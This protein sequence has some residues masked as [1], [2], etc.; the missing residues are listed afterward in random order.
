MAKRQVKFKRPTKVTKLD[1]VQQMAL[2]RE[3]LLDV[4]EEMSERVTVPNMVKS[5]QH[6]VCELAFDTAPNE[7]IAT[8][9]LHQIINYHVEEILE[10]Q[11][12]E[13]ENASN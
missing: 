1:K 2:V 5:L 10:Q 9:L 8:H 3:K 12:K 6:F 7:L 13:C 4:T 11:E